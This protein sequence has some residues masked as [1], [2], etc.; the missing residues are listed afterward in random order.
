M[1]GGLI[2]L[3]SSGK[4]DSYLTVKPEITYFRKIYRRH[5]IFGIELIQI[6]PEQQSEYDNRVSFKLNNIS[7]LI[8]KCYIEIEIPTLSFTENSAVSQL[9]VNELENLQKTSAK[10]KILYENLKRYCVIE[11][12][13]YQTL[14]K[15]LD[16]VNINLNI[17]KQNV[18]RFNSKYKKLKEDLVNLIFDDIFTQINLTGYI[19][20]LSKAIVVDDYI[21]YNETLNIYVSDLKYDIETYYKNMIKNM[22]Y[23]HSNWKYYQK[24]YDDLKNNNIHFG[25]INNLAHYYFTDFEIE[26]GGQVVESYSAEQSF[27]YQTHHLKEEFK[28]NYDDI[29]GANSSLTQYDNLKKL[30]K[31]LILPLNFWF[32]KDIGCA[33]PTVALSNSSV[34]INLKLNKLKSLLYFEDYEQEY[35]NMTKITI[36]YD[37]TIHNNLNILEYKYDTNSR[38][39]TYIC[40]NINYQLL[41]LKFPSLA[42]TQ[43]TPYILTQIL[44]T[45]G[46]QENSEYIMEL[47]EWL[48]YKKNYTNN[49][50]IMNILNRDRLNNYNEYYS[51]V[52]KPNLKLITESVYLDDLERNKF[53]STKLEYVV[54]IF[55]ENAFDLDKKL[56]F[57][58]ELSIDK[59]VKE[60]LWTIQPKLFLNGLSEYGKPYNVFKF[61]KFFTNKFYNSYNIS[62]DQLQINKFNLNELFYN[63]LQS[64]QYY[65][66][67]LP[68]GVSAYNFGLFPEEIQPSG[69]ANFSMLKGKLINFNLNPEFINEYFNT[70][71]NKNLVGLL[72][73]FYAR[74]YNFFVIEKGMG[75]MIFASG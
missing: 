49:P 5:T 65:N 52:D 41:S 48:I 61:D 4:E 31:T 30:K 55:Q 59:P 60:L 16:S 69:T 21:D 46:R 17:I 27:I 57:N 47:K 22:K 66:N 50:T 73:K 56:L 53:S 14:N 74:S 13:L 3:V 10:W 54:E 45:Y 23:Y 70:Q 26:I 38:L 44:N 7:D 71:L 62:L 1:T 63:S 40:K 72:V 12:L 29:I 34:T 8:G 37:N 9:K 36:P 6:L 58:A 75:Q 42:D 35:Y 2:Q 64:Y 28:K 25:W 33:L 43:S 67:A 20:Q 15:L 68:D 18:I 32:C 19:L 39:A 51:L 24:K 11:I